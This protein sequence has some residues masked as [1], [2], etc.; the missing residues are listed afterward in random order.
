M[1]DCGEGGLE[2][3]LVRLTFVWLVALALLGAARPSF[4]SAPSDDAPIPVKYLNGQ[5]RSS[6]D[7]SYSDLLAADALAQCWSTQM[8]SGAS[9]FYSEGDGF[10]T[11]LI[12]RMNMASCY[13]TC[14]YSPRSYEDVQICAYMESRKDPY[15][16]MDR[17]LTEYRAIDVSTLRA[18]GSTSAHLSLCMAGPL[19]QKLRTA[20]VAVASGDDLERVQEMVRERSLTAVY[21]YT[22]LS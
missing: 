11:G 10:I 5:M 20:Q 6:W 4:A 21:Q 7:G 14:P 2:M 12:N 22:I 3:K 19:R 17:S 9:N 15:C 8:D 18:S 1:C 16:N 13:T